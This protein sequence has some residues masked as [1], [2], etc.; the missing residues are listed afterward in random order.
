MEIQINGGNIA[1]KVEW[2]V[3]K[4]E[5]EVSVGEVFENSEMVDT[6]SIT[7]G[8]GTQGV[9]KRYGITT[10]P[11]KTRRGNRKVGCIGAWHPA[12]VKWTVARS[13]QL[14]YYHRTQINQKIF[15]VGAGAVR[16][17]N[18]NASTESDPHVKNITPIGGFPHYGV[19]NEDFLLIRGACM[20]PKKR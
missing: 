5:K 20:G 16:G 7:I 14:G 2:A 6:I 4:F 8:K 11:R 19:V 17:I 10:L 13:G 15:R 12:A 3:S 1:Q 18:N 9:C